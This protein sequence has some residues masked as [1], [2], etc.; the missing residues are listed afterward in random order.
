MNKGDGFGPPLFRFIVGF[1]AVLATVSGLPTA[2][3]E[4]FEKYTIRATLFW[5]SSNKS[6]YDNFDDNYY[7][8]ILQYKLDIKK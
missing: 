7:I 8:I 5:Y 3:P 4:L 1:W 6:W 2:K